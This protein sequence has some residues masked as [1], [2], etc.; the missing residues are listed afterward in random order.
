MIPNQTQRR[1]YGLEKQKQSKNVVNC[2]SLSWTKVCDCVKKER[3][4]NQPF[5]YNKLKI[6]K[7]KRETSKVRDDHKAD[8]A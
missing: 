8:H 6:K 7:L 1:K 3:K 4:I 2:S 5:D